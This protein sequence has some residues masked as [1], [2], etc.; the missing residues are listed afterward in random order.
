MPEIHYQ[1]YPTFEPKL[2]RPIKKVEI[3]HDNI[4]ITDENNRV[5]QFWL[6]MDEFPLMQMVKP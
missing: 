6:G 5:Y 3:S 1:Q 4:F 2:G